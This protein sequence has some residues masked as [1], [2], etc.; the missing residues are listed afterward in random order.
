M[1]PLL[2][3][4]RNIRLKRMRTHEKEIKHAWISGYLMGITTCA[5]ICSAVALYEAS[6]IPDDT[7]HVPA[8]EI[9]ES[10]PA[11]HPAEDGKFI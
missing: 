10:C 1:H 4:Q 6:E 8:I 11:D 3:L 2:K 7:Q 5:V 9:L